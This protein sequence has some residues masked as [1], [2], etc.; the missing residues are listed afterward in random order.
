MNKQDLITA[1]QV[2]AAMLA[3]GANPNT[4]AADLKRLAANVKKGK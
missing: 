3:S 1:L 2:A 4:V